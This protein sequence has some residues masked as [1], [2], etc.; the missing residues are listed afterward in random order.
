MGRR[1]LTLEKRDHHWSGAFL[2]LVSHSARTAVESSDSDSPYTNTADW[3]EVQQ[4]SVKTSGTSGSCGERVQGCRR[5]GT[6]RDT[7]LQFYTW[8]AYFHMCEGFYTNVGKKLD[9]FA[10]RLTPKT[11]AFR[12]IWGVFL[13]PNVYYSEWRWGV[14]KGVRKLSPLTSSL[15]EWSES[16]LQQSFPDNPGCLL[17]NLF[18]KESKFIYLKYSMIYIE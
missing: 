11:A 4:M 18:F 9:I 13:F 14:E 17:R 16:T 1:G 10:C 7:L 15:F 8:R 6:D 5:G 3:R 2:T 12:D